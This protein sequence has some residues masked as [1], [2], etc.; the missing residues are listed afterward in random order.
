VHKP[1]VLFINLLPSI[2]GLLNTLSRKQTTE[3]TSSM[4]MLRAA[5]LAVLLLLF[6]AC[7]SQKPA[8]VTVKKRAQ[9]EA[10]KPSPV[11]AKADLVAVKAKPE[12]RKTPKPQPKKAETTPAITATSTQVADAKKAAELPKQTAL[13]P[14]ELAIE[15]AETYLGVRYRY[16]GNTRNGIDCSGLMNEAYKEIGVSIPRTSG[17]IMSATDAIL[18]DHVEP[19]DFVFFATG[20]SKARVS[21]V[22]MVTRVIDGDVEFIHSSTSQG[23]IKSML[24]ESYW[25]NAFLRAGRLEDE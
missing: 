11:A 15:A 13:S 21:H 22:G 4:Y 16:A 25:N 20:R 1:L 7:G 9:T 3:T 19:G 6:T 10:A 2:M 17:G 12:P 24:S 14:G 18:L 8:V 5:S 23:V